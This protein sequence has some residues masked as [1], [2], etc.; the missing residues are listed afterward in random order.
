MNLYSKYLEDNLSDKFKK[1]L[2][3]YRKYL[4]MFFTDNSKCPIDSKILIEKEESETQIKLWCKSKTKKEWSVTI[5]KPK[6]V[7]L[8]HK[9]NQLTVDYKNQGI[10]FRDYLKE[11]MLSP[12]YDPDKDKD[13]ENKL[14]SLKQVESELQAV[15]DVFDQQNKKEDD[16]IKKRQE[17]LVKLLEIKIK[18]SNI[19]KN[20]PVIDAETKRKLMEIA[21]NEK[22]I[23]EA[24]LSQISK[25]V[26]L[27]NDE[28]KNW[29]QYF[30][31]IIEYLN[32]NGNLNGLNEEMKRLRD[33]FEEINDYYVV[34]PPV[35]EIY[36]AEKKEEIEEEVKKRT[37]KIKK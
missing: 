16:L 1:S 24:R 36:P 5:T 23:T 10:L 29:I 4:K 11:N 26:N 19:Y 32:E 35:F 3:E 21:K 30:S 27:K 34:E 28:T 15:K 6:I 31:L 2:D 33:K 13:A 14:K 25:N 8:N 7:N 17:L 20:C 18:K 9:L 22:T 37:I 12:I